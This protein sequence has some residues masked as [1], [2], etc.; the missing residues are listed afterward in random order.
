MVITQENW[1]G[2]SGF[3]LFSVVFLSPKF[4]FKATLI[5]ATDIWLVV[6]W[7]S[8]WLDA[9]DPFNHSASA[10]ATPRKQPNTTGMENPAAKLM[11]VAKPK[12]AKY[13]TKGRL[14]CDRSNLMGLFFHSKAETVI[15]TAPVPH[16]PAKF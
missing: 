2:D 6:D 1:A 7:V 12:L 14:S 11:T 9:A 16:Q 15:N 8:V 4:Y 3:W 13:T 10:G 5:F